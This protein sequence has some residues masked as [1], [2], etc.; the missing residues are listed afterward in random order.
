MHVLICLAPRHRAGVDPSGA[1]GGAVSGLVTALNCLDTGILAPFCAIGVVGTQ[2]LVGAAVDCAKDAAANCFK[3]SISLALS[4]IL[5]EA[6][7]KL[8]IFANT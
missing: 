4:F 2:A 5:L 7:S 1:A 8:L 6:R 3:G